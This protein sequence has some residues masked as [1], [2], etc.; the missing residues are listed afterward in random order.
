M[1][2]RCKN[3]VRKSGSRVRSG[4]RAGLRKCK[5]SRSRS[6]VRLVRPSRSRVRLVRP[7]RSRCK[8]DVRKVA[9]VVQSKPRVGLR[10]YKKSR[11]PPV[12]QSK[13]RVGLRKYKKSRSPRA[14]LRKYKKSRSPTVRRSRSRSAS[15]CKYGVRASGPL[16]RSG[17]RAGLRKCI[18]SKAEAS[19]VHN[20]VVNKEELQK[21]SQMLEHYLRG[22]APPK[23]EENQPSVE[24]FVGIQRQ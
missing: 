12:V 23:L 11:S 19:Q 3:G 15:H 2:K 22:L 10:K 8:T 17:P 16:V 6:R 5:K 4:P 21:Q 24:E 1:P 7:V 13:P 9:P 20:V 18:R 14:V